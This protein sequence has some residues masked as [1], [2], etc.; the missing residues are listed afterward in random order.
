MKIAIVEDD[1]QVYER[2]QTYLSELL[3]SSAEYIYFPSG[4]IFL[5]SWRKGAFDLIIL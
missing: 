2:L 4:E 3:G 5:K 1:L